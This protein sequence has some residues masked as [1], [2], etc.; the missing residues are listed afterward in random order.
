MLNLSGRVYKEVMKK[1]KYA[2][3]KQRFCPDKDDFDAFMAVIE[4]Y[5]PQNDEEFNLEIHVLKICHQRESETSNVD[6]VI[7]R[8]SHRRCSVKKTFLKISQYSQENICVGCKFIEKRLQ[9]RR[10]PVN[11]VKFLRTPILENICEWLLLYKI[12]LSSDDLKRHITKKHRSSKAQ[13]ISSS[14][15][16]VSDLVP[17]TKI[18]LF[19]KLICMF[20]SCHVRASEQIY[21]RVA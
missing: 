10:F 15:C 8:S 13:E 6:F 20:L 5:M 14:D 21:S 2:F 1:L 9:H 4:T 17:T 18:K 16:F 19:K 3:Q 7:N 12:Y 11:I